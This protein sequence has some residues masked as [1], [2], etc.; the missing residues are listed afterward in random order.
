LSA[1][2]FQIS[3]FKFQGALKNQAIKFE[4]L[5]LNPL[6]SVDKA[7]K[8]DKISNL[9]AQSDNNGCLAT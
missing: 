6:K 1:V 8:I 4:N 3:D 2:G 5:F 9:I 7:F